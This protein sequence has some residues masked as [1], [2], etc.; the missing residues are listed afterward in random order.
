MTLRKK[1]YAKDLTNEIGSPDSHETTCKELGTKTI[2]IFSSYYGAKL[3]LGN[4][5]M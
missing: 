4:L 1:I 3:S 5:N 2:F